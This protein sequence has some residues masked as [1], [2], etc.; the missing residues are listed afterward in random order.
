MNRDSFMNILSLFSRMPPGSVSI[1]RM[2]TC[3]HITQQSK[4]NKHVMGIPFGPSNQQ[5][6]TT[7]P[8][9]QI[10]LKTTFIGVVL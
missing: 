5:V 8:I 9:T 1:P 10:N 4:T 2:F 6:A 7:E 3:Y